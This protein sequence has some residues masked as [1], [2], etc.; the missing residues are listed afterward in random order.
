[1]IMDRKEL[2]T[3]AS[4]AMLE[5]HEDE[6]ASLSTAV[7]TM[8]DYFSLM[9]EVDITGLE[10][11]THAFSSQHT[12]RPDVRCKAASQQTAAKELVERAAGH[13]DEYFIIPNVL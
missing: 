4:L 1:M 11:T 3:T 6:I 8:L 13:D 9:S 12:A 7:T 5:L 10:P 2:E